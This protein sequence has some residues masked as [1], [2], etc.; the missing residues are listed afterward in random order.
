MQ[1]DLRC[2]RA[3]RDPVGR[4]LRQKSVNGGI[5]FFLRG[6]RANGPAGMQACPPP[7]AEV[8]GVITADPLVRPAGQRIE[9]LAFAEI[10][11]AMDDGTIHANVHSAKWP[12]GEIPGQLR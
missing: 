2:T 1:A 3:G 8:T 12:G 11:V 9:A 4:A 10:V 7:P 5:R 6:N